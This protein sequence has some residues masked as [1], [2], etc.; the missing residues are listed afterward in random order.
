[1]CIMKKK[2]TSLGEMTLCETKLLTNIEFNYE[3]ESMYRIVIKVSDHAGLSRITKFNVTIGD[4]N[5]APSNVTVR[6]EIRMQVKENMLDMII[7]ELRT[8]DED[9]MQTFKYVK[10]KNVCFFI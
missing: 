2:L 6:G 7:G 3:E 4:R 10:M 5:D 9:Q 1:M 8:I